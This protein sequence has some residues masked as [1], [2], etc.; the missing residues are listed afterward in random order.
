MTAFLLDMDGV[1]YR[2]DRVIDGAREFMAAIADRPHAFLTN[3][4][5]LPPER[6]Q[7]RLHRLGLLPAPA[8]PLITSALAT[9]EHLQRTHPG[10]RYFAVGGE[11]LHAA[12]NAVG[13]PSDEDADYVIIG[14]GDGLDYATLTRGG[15]M[16]I[17]GSRLVV[18]NPD[19]N[20]DDGS[21][22]LP[23][24]GA[25]VAPFEVMSGQ[26][27]LVIGKPEPALYEAGMRALGSTP[28]NT[29][30]V[31]DRPDTDIAG[32]A[33]L[34]MRTLLVRTGRFGPDAA[35]PNDLPPPSWDVNDLRDWSLP[36][37]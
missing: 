11:G 12:L 10:F 7:A 28:K 16:L 33:R 4:S 34:G 17:R 6:F 23:G 29:I 1:L 35:Y 15:N 19:S 9:A 5:S 21:R 30:M 22:V 37:A 32:A 20:V 26:Q 2:G 18:T 25:L 24:G 27:A 8:A 36:A 14:E 3:N 13:E 31:G